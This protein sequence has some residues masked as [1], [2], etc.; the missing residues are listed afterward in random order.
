MKT[1]A[2][3]RD[4]DALL[5][6]DRCFFEALVA[7]DVTRLGELLAEDFVLVGVS[8]GAV[9]DRDALL[10]AVASGAVRFPS[11]RAFPEEAV[12]RRIGDVGIVV[13][14]TDMSFTGDDGAGNGRTGDDGTGDRGTGDGRTG[15]DGAAFT[16]GS[17]YT[18]VFARSSGSDQWCLMSAQ[19]TVIRS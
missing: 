7:G 17:R 8:D 6:R 4:R 13:G 10:G 3:P 19:G 14:R 1:L 11:V 9:V 12:V 16:S 18:H 2:S 15:D 5:D